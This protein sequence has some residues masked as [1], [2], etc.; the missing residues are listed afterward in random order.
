MGAT[1][2]TTLD[3]SPQ[4]VAE[5]LNEL[6]EA[7]DWTNKRR[8]YHLLSTVL[9]ALRDWLTVDEAADLSAQLPILMRGIYFEGWDPSG[10]PV[11]HRNKTDFLGRIEKAFDVEP[12]PDVEAAIRAVFKLLDSHI[13]SGEISQVRH[14]LKK[15][16]RE[17]WP[18]D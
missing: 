14:A 5:W 10:T 12:L 9:H 15:E 8:A 6:N 2:V 17:L 4:V 7:L 16:L 13:S 11:R 3:H 18:S 1:G